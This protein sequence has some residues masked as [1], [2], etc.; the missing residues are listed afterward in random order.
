LKSSRL[1]KKEREGV[2]ESG[3]PVEPSLS[4]KGL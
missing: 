3:N 4:V 1:F 2:D